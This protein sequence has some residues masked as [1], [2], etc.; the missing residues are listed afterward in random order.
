MIAAL[1]FA[2]T[3]NITGTYHS[4]WEDVRL[5]QHGTQISGTYVCCGGGTIHG[6]VD[7]NVIHY[8]WRQPGGEGRGVWVIG[9]PDH[10]SGTWG[11]DAD[12]ANGGRWDLV[13]SNAI[14][15]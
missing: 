14:A 12:E 5:V 11:V 7:G 1:P 6:T 4:N 15:H 2:A 13:L 9:P 8:R 3:P 10:L